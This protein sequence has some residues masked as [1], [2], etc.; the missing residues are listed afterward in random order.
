MRFEWEGLSRKKW[1][2]MLLGSSQDDGL[3]LKIEGWSRD[4]W[5]FCEKKRD[6]GM[7]TAI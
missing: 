1:I 3:R 4:F 2:E 5:Q 6:T 7:A